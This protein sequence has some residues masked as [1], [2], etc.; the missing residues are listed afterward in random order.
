MGL[1]ITSCQ[2]TTVPDAFFQEAAKVIADQSDYKT[3][4]RLFPDVHRIRDISLDIAVRVCEV[5]SEM[6]IANRT[7]SGIG[8]RE[9]IVS[10]RWD[11]QWYSPVVPK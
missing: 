10:K 2:A 5:A 11:P 3:N 6:G 7:M 9:Y 1:G 4:G 8:W